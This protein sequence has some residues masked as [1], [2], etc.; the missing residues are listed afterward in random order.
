MNRSP[1]LGLAIA[2]L[3]VAAAVLPAFAGGFGGGGT[4]GASFN[5]R[6]P[7]SPLAAPVPG[8]DLSR[9]HL[10]ASVMM[11]S[12]FGGGVSGLQVTSLSYRFQA[13][14]WMNVSVGNVLG[15]N[16]TRTGHSFFLEGFD[17]GYNPTP[18]MAFQIHYRDLR[19][20]LQLPAGYSPWSP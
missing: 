13:P 18:N 14:L 15:S 19:S 12:G 8:L 4:P 10:S 5:P 7:I 1:A 2:S 11:G 9:L 16:M 20:P 17:V 6:V 3:A